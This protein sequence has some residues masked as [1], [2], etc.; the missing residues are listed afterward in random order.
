MVVGEGWEVVGV[1]GSRKGPGGRGA[2]TRAGE[3]L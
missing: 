3:G 2:A 1:W